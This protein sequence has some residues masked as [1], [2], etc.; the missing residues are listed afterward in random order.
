MYFHNFS[1][2]DWGGK[3]VG[4]TKERWIKHYFSLNDADPVIDIFQQLGTLNLSIND[5]NDR[6]LPAVLKPLEEFICTVYRSND[7]VISSISELRWELYR[8][9]NCEGEKLPPTLASFYPHILTL[10]VVCRRDPNLPTL[11]V[12]GWTTQN[13]K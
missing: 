10:S 3:F 7:C 4:V 13:G 9:K 11:D 12:S 5:F 2:A 6:E 8:T 1:G